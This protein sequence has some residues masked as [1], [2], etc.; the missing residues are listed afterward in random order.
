M[1]LDLVVEPAVQEVVDVTAGA[2]VDG[3]DDGAEVEVIGLDLHGRLEA[4]Y[5]LARVVGH[6]D[7]EGVHVGEDL[8][9]EEGG[10]GGGSHG[11]A[12]ECVE[13]EGGDDEVRGEV[14]HQAREHDLGRKEV[15]LEHLGH[16]VLDGG[17]LG[18]VPEVARGLG[19][20]ERLGDTV[21]ALLLRKHDL[22]VVHLLRTQASRH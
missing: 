7:E 14:G 2:E 5:V 19:H 15:E 13:D 18:H 8:S 12:E 1:V 3:A 16:N 4:V 17:G 9:G 10:E 20:L 22:A 21:V 11:L 6:D